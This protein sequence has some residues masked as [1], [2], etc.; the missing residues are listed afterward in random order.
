MEYHLYRE[1]HNT[2]NTESISMMDADKYPHHT[3]AM[4]EI[5]HT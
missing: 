5:E 4:H 1:I 2:I 3:I